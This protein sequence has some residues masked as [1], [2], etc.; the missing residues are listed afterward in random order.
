[1][2]VSLALLAGCAG[3][4]KAPTAATPPAT[5]PGSTSNAEPTP[6]PSTITD[7]E[8]DTLLSDFNR[9]VTR[10][11]TAVEGAGGDCGQIASGIERVVGEHGELLT[12][13]GELGD[14]PAVEDRVAAWLTAHEREVK[15][16]AERLWGYLAPCQPDPAVVAAVEKLSA[17]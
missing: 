7:A 4:A 15:P 3:P 9:F 6:P 5:R 11:T 17:M 1:M 16:V 2:I 12:R 10:V 14:D 8:L 13:V